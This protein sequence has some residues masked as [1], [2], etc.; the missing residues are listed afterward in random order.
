MDI[1]TVVTILSSQSVESASTPRKLCV[2]MLSNTDCAY[3]LRNRFRRGSYFLFY[4]QNCSRNNTNDNGFKWM[5]T[6][7]IDHQRK[8]ARVRHDDRVL[9]REIVE[10]Q[11][12]QHPAADL[13]RI[14]QRLGQREHIGAGD[15][16]LAAHAMPAGDD[17]LAV[18]CERNGRS[19]EMPFIFMLAG[20]DDDDVERQRR[21]RRHATQFKYGHK[22]ANVVGPD[23][24]FVC[25]R[26][27]RR[28]YARTEH[29]DADVIRWHSN[30]WHTAHIATR[31]TCKRTTDRSVFFCIMNTPS[32]SSLPPARQLSPNTDHHNNTPTSHRRRRRRRRE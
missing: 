2:E 27:L 26:T 18:L 20:R 3:V 5:C 19:V 22:I 32:H 13:H 24:A 23:T 16:A 25:C 15:L 10:R 9:H 1:W 29:A 14:R 30:E 12:A 17:F 11:A 8:A 28:S 7:R 31:T 4:I 21:R 6:L